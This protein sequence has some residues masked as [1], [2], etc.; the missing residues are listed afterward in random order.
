MN[1]TPV[2]DTG[3][4]VIYHLGDVSA[5]IYNSQNYI[6]GAIKALPSSNWDYQSCVHQYPNSWSD[7][8]TA[9]TRDEAIDAAISDYIAR[10]ISNENTDY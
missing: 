3:F 5:Y 9:P 4:Y 2:G 8:D 7:P 1:K 10:L 6:V